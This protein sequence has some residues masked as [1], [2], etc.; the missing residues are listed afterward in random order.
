MHYYYS[1]NNPYKISN[2]SLR[3][4][5]DALPGTPPL[6]KAALVGAMTLPLVGATAGYVYGGIRHKNKLNELNKRLA[7]TVDPYE[8]EVIQYRINHFTPE[9]AF[10]KRVGLVGAGLVAGGVL[11]HK[12][13]KPLLK[14]I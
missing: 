12:L 8:R 4:L 13:S 3:D 2:F 9:S 11:Q 7:E 1:L 10:L 6:K 5:A 14:W